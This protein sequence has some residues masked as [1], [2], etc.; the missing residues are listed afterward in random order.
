MESLVQLVLYI[1]KN[2]ENVRRDLANIFENLDLQLVAELRARLI[3][4]PKLAIFD[5]PVVHGVLVHC[6]PRNSVNSPEFSMIL[7]AINLY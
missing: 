2:F 4:H 3:F 7:C 5:G 1:L 6:L